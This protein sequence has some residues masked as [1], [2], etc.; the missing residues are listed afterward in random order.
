MLS[1][2]RRIMPAHAQLARTETETLVD[3]DHIN[4]RT[5]LTCTRWP[6]RLI[7]GLFLLL[8]DRASLVGR[9]LGNCSQ[10]KMLQVMFFA[11]VRLAMQ[12]VAT[13]QSV[14]HSMCLWVA[15]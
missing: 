8:L 1:L 10:V 15:L 13:C 4:H 2:A 9:S 7:D 6:T 14:A 5:A 11:Y 3:F 12:H